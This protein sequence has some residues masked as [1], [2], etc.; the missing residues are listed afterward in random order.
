MSSRIDLDERRAA[1]C[2]ELINSWG[3]TFEKS[4]LLK[5]LSGTTCVSMDVATNLLRAENG[6]KKQLE[7]FISEPVESNNVSFYAPIQKNK[8]EAFAFVL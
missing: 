1:K 4:D 5:S 2:Y 6:R 3:N 8:L 7:K